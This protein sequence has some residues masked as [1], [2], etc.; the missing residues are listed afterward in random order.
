MN[1]ELVATRE[2]RREGSKCDV[3]R[4]EW[5]RRAEAISGSEER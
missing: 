2:T 4:R 3:A 5:L 1:A